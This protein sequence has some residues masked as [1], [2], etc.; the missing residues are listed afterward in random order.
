MEQLVTP[1]ILS[2]LIVLLLYKLIEGQ[3]RKK[4]EKYTYYFLLLILFFSLAYIR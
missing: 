4:G 1:I 2:I 3:P